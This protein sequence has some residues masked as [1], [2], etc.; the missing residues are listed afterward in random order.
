MTR[1]T[2]ACATWCTKWWISVWSSISSSTTITFSFVYAR[3]VYR[4]CALVGAIFK[5]VYYT[6]Y[7]VVLRHVLSVVGF[8]MTVASQISKKVYQWKNFGNQL[9]IAKDVVRSRSEYFFSGHGVQPRAVRG[10]R[11]WITFLE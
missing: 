4:C 5:N 9:R 11:I 7:K 3:S 2:P 6:L 8:Q 1:T 10:T